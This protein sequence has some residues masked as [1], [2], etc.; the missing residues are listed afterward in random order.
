MFDSHSIYN[1]YSTACIRSERMLVVVMEEG[2]RVPPDPSS[3]HTPTQPLSGGL[4][5]F[6]CW[7]LGKSWDRSREIRT[8]S[9][10]LLLGMELFQ[11]LNNHCGY[12]AEYEPCTVGSSHFQYRDRKTQTPKHHFNC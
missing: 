6:S 5:C 2:P 8:H 7:I 12:T 11:Y 3:P 9:A 4:Y 1:S 10:Y